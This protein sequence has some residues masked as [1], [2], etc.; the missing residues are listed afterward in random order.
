MVADG[1]AVRATPQRDTG[2]AGRSTSRATSLGAPR[3]GTGVPDGSIGRAGPLG[4]EVE[5]AAGAVR[6]DGARRPGGCA[7]PVEG[8]RYSDASRWVACV[9]R[10]CPSRCSVSSSSRSRIDRRSGGRLAL[11]LDGGLR[12][13]RAAP[14]ARSCRR[15]SGSSRG[16]SLRSQSSPVCTVR[17]PASASTCRSRSRSSAG[18][19]GSGTSSR[20]PRHSPECGERRDRPANRSHL[21]PAGSRQ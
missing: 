21:A 11:S 10:S 2:E 18:V 4:R 15:I 19:P 8:Q 13:G 20:P 5:R 3:D 6:R 17:R 16:G 9:H 12:I 1:P 7:P 14:L